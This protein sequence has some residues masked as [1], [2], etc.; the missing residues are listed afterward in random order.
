MTLEA[1]AAEVGLTPGALYHHFGSKEAL[2]FECFTRGLGFYRREIERARE[3]GLDGLEAVR[4][5]VR[6]RLRPGEPRMITFSDID[7][8]PKAHRDAVHEGRARNVGLL[9]ELV[10]GGV[11]D[12]SIAP[13][14]PLLTSLAVFSVLDW[15]PFWYSESSYYTRQDA[16]EAIDDILTHGVL[17]RDILE[18]APEPPPDFAPL[19]QALTPRD[20][21][22]AK[23][24]RLLK[25]ATESFNRRGVVGSS[26]EQIASDASVSRSAYY[27]HASDK[28][29]LLYLCLE[30]ACRVE[31]QGLDFLLR[32]TTEIDDPVVRAVAMETHVLH[33]SAM[34][35]ASPHGPKISFHDVPFLSPEQLQAF[36]AMNRALSTRNEARYVEAIRSGVFRP[37]DSHFVQEI[38]AGLRN[39]LPAWSRLT[40]A[41]ADTE[42]AGNHAA[43]F[44]YGLKPRRE[45]PPPQN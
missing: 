42:V 45:A 17:R 41:Y 33:F 32:S 14:D 22:A 13:R 39:H 23:R 4:R 20:R 1:I 8:L 29:Q 31:T 27:Y 21:R 19:S 30:R 26:L 37:L 10:A 25:I 44:L 36:A 16:A 28:T 7:A 11:A 6:G 34:L 38:G 40:R 3:P 15:M 43:L 9:S 12:G 35:H 2:V 18:R 5:F 24:D